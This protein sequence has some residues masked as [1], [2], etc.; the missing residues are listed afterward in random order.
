MS[1][2]KKSSST[3]LNRATPFYVNV[4]QEYKK[5]ADNSFAKL[6]TNTSELATLKEIA[7]VFS[8]FVDKKLYTDVAKKHLPHTFTSTVEIGDLKG[9]KGVHHRLFLDIESE[10]TRSTVE[11]IMQDY[12]YVSYYSYNHGVKSE[13][14]FRLIVDL[15]RAYTSEEFKYAKK[16]LIKMFPFVDTVSFE[17]NRIMYLPVLYDGKRNP[18]IKYNEG[19]N[20]SLEKLIIET[21][22]QEQSTKIQVT[23][24][25]IEI[26][27]DK[28]YNKVKREKA[29][30]NAQDMFKYVGIGE[31]HKSLFNASVILKSACFSLEEALTL[32]GQYETTEHRGK[33]SRDWDSIEAQPSDYFLEDKSVMELLKT[34]EHK[35][36][37][38][39]KNLIIIDKYIS[40]VKD[41]IFSDLKK[42]KKILINAD[43]NTGKTHLF[44]NTTD[45]IIL[46]Q[47]YVILA[48][49]TFK[50]AKKLYKNRKISLVQNGTKPDFKADLIITTYDGLQKFYSEEGKEWLKTARFV[51]D[52][53]HNI[54]TSSSDDFRQNAIRKIVENE[55]LANEI[56]YLTATPIKDSNFEDIHTINIQRKIRRKKKLYITKYDDRVQAV[57]DAVT[58]SKKGSRHVIFINNKK[59]N[60][61]LD[62]IFTDMGYNCQVVNTDV[63]NDYEVKKF[64]ETGELANDIDILISTSI[65]SEGFRIDA[66]ID[67]LHVLSLIG[68]EQLHQFSERPSGNAIKNTIIY[69]KDTSVSSDRNTYSPITEKSNLVNYATGLVKVN[70]VILHAEESKNEYIRKQTNISEIEKAALNKQLSKDTAAYKLTHKDERN[71]VYFNPMRDEF[72][73][74][75]LGINFL[76]YDKTKHFN[77]KN[78]DFL[79]DELV[80]LYNFTF[81]Q[82][83]VT[84]NSNKRKT[85][86]KNDMSEHSKV[87]KAD[88]LKI[89][90]GII[91]EITNTIQANPHDEF[92]DYEDEDVIANKYIKR[93]NS[94]NYLI[95]DPQISL[96]LLKS[97]GIN[98]TASYH[99]FITSY[100]LSKQEDTG[101]IAQLKKEIIIGK[102]YT[103]H[104][105]N[106]IVKNIF[107]QNELTNTKWKEDT[108]KTNTTT[109]YLK[110]IFEMTPITERK[111]KD[112]Y[113]T[114]NIKSFMAYKNFID[115]ELVL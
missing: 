10:I 87:N 28:K 61:Q 39:P 18:E 97:F 69:K 43:A 30:Q 101:I 4:K 115:V 46:I 98:R 114:Y 38:I 104:E 59:V 105:L 21:N 33:I 72:E 79:V 44:L 99:N 70:N 92:I 88:M 106:F 37:H 65:L 40:E 102:R 76:V 95:N 56:V 89:F 27:H 75:E 26:P 14:R 82:D 103:A 57:V 8:E 111:G 84:Y 53:A 78:T 24:K 13:N 15:D 77:W 49:Q 112:I 62:A 36:I 85:K 71:L 96:E 22:I 11:N 50:K 52:E 51:V 25:K 12:G 2:K 90:D 34:Y 41:I 9:Q 42:H 23:N 7:N 31:T 83:N 35:P 20:F 66:D 86:L 110:K 47:P 17:T 100:N 5:L 32:I 48:R 55:F 73:I 64:I 54:T 6:I 58:S 45:R 67:T 1:N 80:G 108:T 16:Q 94:I 29:V 74:N 109:L 81:S 91:S 107:K 19:N 68:A 113:E 63:M 93:Y 60:F 3:T